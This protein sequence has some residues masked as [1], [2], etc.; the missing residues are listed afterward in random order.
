MAERVKLTDEQR[1]HKWVRREVLRMTCCS[2]CGVVKRTDGMNGPCRGPAYP[3]L[4][5]ALTQEGEG[6]S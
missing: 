5:S 3:A 1:E 4:R 2:L 6:R